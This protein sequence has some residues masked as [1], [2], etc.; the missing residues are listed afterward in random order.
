MAQ[1]LPFFGGPCA[2]GSMLV[3]CADSWARLVLHVSRVSEDAE[4]L[5]ESRLGAFVLVVDPAR[6]TG[7]NLHHRLSIQASGV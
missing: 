7:L 5:G 3:S 4:V 1:A 2:S 6:R